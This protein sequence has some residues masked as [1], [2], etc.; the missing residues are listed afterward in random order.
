MSTTLL[1]R[2]TR[3]E[4]AARPRTGGVDLICRRF[5]SVDGND[6]AVRA[7][8]G[9]RILERTED[10]TEEAFVQRAQAEALASTDW[11]PCVI[12][13]LPEEALT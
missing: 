8:I 13:L 4:K 2:L 9:G 6:E 3:L 11:R 12:T 1:N 5:I 10:E 7:R